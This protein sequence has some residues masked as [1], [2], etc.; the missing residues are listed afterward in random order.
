TSV[1]P[2]I[3]YLGLRDGAQRCRWARSRRARVLLRLQA[4]HATT[5]PTNAPAMSA[6]VTAAS[7]H[8]HTGALLTRPLSRQ[9]PSPRT[10]RGIGH[11]GVRGIGCFSAGYPDP[12]VAHPR[13]FFR[14]AETHR[15]FPGYKKAA[16]AHEGPTRAGR[17]SRAVILKTLRLPLLGR[18]RRRA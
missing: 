13:D 1:G 18:A 3:V 4:I 8:C 2:S 14:P 7:C 10:L 15:I 9:Q 6:A 16:A 11:E 12:R 17:P 5:T